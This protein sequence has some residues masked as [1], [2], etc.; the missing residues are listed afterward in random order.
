MPYDDLEWIKSL[1]LY[2]DL[3]DVWLVHAGVK[4]ETPLK[5]QTINEFCWIR[6]DFHHIEKPFFKDK[7]IITGHTITFTF[8]GVEPGELVRGKG[9]LDIDTSAYHHKS[10]W[11]TALDID[12][13]LAYQVN[14]FDNLKRQVPLE[15][16]VKEYQVQSEEK[17]QS[18]LSRLLSMKL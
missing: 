12:N 10:G 14:V 3:G 2:L 13:K 8:E 15:E 4:P 6:K 5:E 17:Q 9:W 11:L 16:I 1:P 7:L 18:L